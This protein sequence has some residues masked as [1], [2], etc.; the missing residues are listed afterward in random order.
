MRVYRQ[1]ILIT[2]LLGLTWPAHAGSFRPPGGT[3][4]EV[5]DFERHVAGLL[6]KLGC[7]AGACHGS[8]QGKGG[9]RLSLFGHD[10]E[11]DFQALTRDAMGR[12]VNTAKPDDSLILLKA[13]AQLP[14]GGGKRL[15][16][17]SWPYQVIR[18]WIAQGARHQGGS[19]PVS[20]IRIQPPVYAFRT[21]GEAVQLKVFVRF[22]DG[23]ESDVTPFC[24]IRAKDDSVAEVSGLGEVRALTPGDTP[25]IASYRGNLA[26]SRILVP[27]ST[28]TV[29]A[30]P[31]VPENGFIDREVFAKLRRLR[32]A[33]SAL[34]GDA[35]FLRR[36]T[37]D[38]I[39]CV[40]AP[41]EVRRFLADNRLDKRERKIDELLAHP[42]HAALWATKFCDTTACNVDVLDGAPELRG[43][44][45]KM[46]H[47][48]FRK[49][50]AENQPL[51]RIVK[52]V[53]TATSRDGQ[54]IERWMEAE[55]ALDRAA[56][57]GFD[58]GYADRPTLDLFWRRVMGEDFFPLEQM[59]EL[60]AT[61]FLGV[62]IE[63]AQCHKHPFDRWTQTDYRA[64]ANVFAQ[65]RF[66]SSPELTAATVDLLER[67]RG[68]APR[69]AGPPIPRLREVY[70]TSHRPRQLP[71]PETN[72]ALPARALGGPAL[73]ATRDLRK[74]LFRWMVQPDNPYFARSFVNRVWAH[75]FG[76]GL[77][78]PVDSFSVANP[79]SNERLLSA[80]AA[81]FV[82]G[83]FD[84]R[85]LERL[86]LQSRTYQLSSTP[87]QANVRDRTNYARAL[88]RPM[89]AEAVVDVLNAALGTVEDFGADAPPG[90]RAIEIASNRVRSEYVA[91][92][93]RIFGRPARSVTCDC[94]RAAGPAVPQT[95]F[96]MSDPVLLQKIHNGRLGQLLAGS[97]SDAD[98]VEELF[99]ASLSRLPEVKEKSAAL[100]Q[101][102]AAK[103]RREGFT[104]VVWALINTREFILNH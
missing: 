20:A 11:H 73:E 77:V 67:R 63:C 48:W 84:I 12:R 39:G 35:E 26:T 32:I 85:R 52:G 64:Y 71:D 31:P 21:P 36:V 89:M 97:R 17:G 72:V 28:G 2:T 41:D 82:A 91:R 44:R 65:V 7:N 95:L 37:I 103:A 14:H 54:E 47:D 69:H 43:R 60:T 22:R 93:F 86:I 5:V 27:F 13:T 42:L 46:W 49:R 80:M 99:L 75:Y 62:R 66:G 51:D 34:S 61:A 104:D 88:A 38:T 40:P 74:A 15:A 101:V 30:W 102:S 70:F 8:F 57:N 10:A 90:S 96:L 6:S 79:P 25:V 3:V 53:L 18:E 83:S 92:V 23:T 100:K 94:E 19:G 1:S 29:S 59:A 24:D 76:L 58:S 16:K 9:L 4:V 50:L 56:R 45:A 68:L 33:P 98:L 81:D 78:D 55:V 87:N